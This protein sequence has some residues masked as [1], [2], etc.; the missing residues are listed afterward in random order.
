MQSD[1]ARGR[2][3][4][5]PWPP[6]GLRA[7]AAAATGKVACC[8]TAAPDGGARLHRRARAT[9]SD[10]RVGSPHMRPPAA[11]PP[12]AAGRRC[13]CRGRDRSCGFDAYISDTASELLLARR[14]P[15]LQPVL[16]KFNGPYSLRERRRSL[17]LGELPQYLGQPARSKITPARARGMDDHH[18]HHFW[19]LSPC[20]NLLELLHGADPG[21]QALAGG[22]A[23]LLQ[24]S[25]A[26]L[27]QTGRG[28]ARAP[29]PLGQA[30]PLPPAGLPLRLPSHA[31]HACGGGGSCAGRRGSC[32]WER[33]RRPAGRGV[34]PRGGRGV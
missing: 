29:L 28:V 9:Q 2:R 12:P 23:A 21:R 16:V 33:D 30:R 6:P 18:V 13:R 26:R 20:V 17:F 11:A 10:A 4:G 7:A 24:A 19:G 3:A 27:T 31:R 14:N 15:P 25:E 1:G 5:R 32:T 8:R 34:A 22:D